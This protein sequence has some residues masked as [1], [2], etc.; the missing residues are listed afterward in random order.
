MF[1]IDKAS[2]DLA[3]CLYA[4]ATVITSQPDPG[5][6]VFLVRASVRPR[7]L[8]KLSDVSKVNMAVDVWSPAA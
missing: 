4:E 5:L 1:R 8:H 3:G 2:R 6:L 7:N